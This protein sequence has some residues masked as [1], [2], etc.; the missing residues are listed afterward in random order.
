MR[1][2]GVVSAD[3]DSVAV[4]SFTL[5]TAINNQFVFKMPKN[6]DAKHI[7]KQHVS[8]DSKLLEIRDNKIYIT[9]KANQII[10][11]KK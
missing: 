11:L 1:G 9:L 5:K 7:T 8:V 3:W 4:K 10:T 2:N 6:W